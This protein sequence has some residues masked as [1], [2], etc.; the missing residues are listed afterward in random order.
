MVAHVIDNY[1]KFGPIAK[2]IYAEQIDGFDDAMDGV[3]HVISESIYKCNLD[4]K[5]WSKKIFRYPEDAALFIKDLVNNSDHFRIQDRIYYA[6]SIW[7]SLHHFNSSRDLA[8]LLLM[9]DEEL[10][11]LMAD[12][13]ELSSIASQGI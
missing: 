3:L 8:E 13:E 10:S 5:G 12:D 2:E 1:R 4:L 6:L 7:G 9:E 11:L